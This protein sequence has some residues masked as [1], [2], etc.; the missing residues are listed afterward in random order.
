MFGK[1][2]TRT[3][4]IALVWAGQPVSKSTTSQRPNQKDSPNIALSYPT[5]NM[6]Y[7]LHFRQVTFWKISCI[8]VT[9]YSLLQKLSTSCEKFI[10]KW[11][12]MAADMVQIRPEIRVDR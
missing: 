8:L 12:G 1:L 3:D 9:L 6:E 4:F 7:P 5:I 11:Q 10:L 2:T